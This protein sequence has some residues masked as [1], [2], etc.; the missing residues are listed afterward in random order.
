MSVHVSFQDLTSEILVRFVIYHAFC[1]SFFVV[2]CLCLLL[3]FWQERSQRLSWGSL[4]NISFS[5]ANARAMITCCVLWEEIYLNSLRIWMHFIATSPSPTR[6]L[7]PY[8]SIVFLT[9]FFTEKIVIHCLI[10]A[11][12][13]CAIISGGEEPWWYPAP[14]LLFRP[15]RTL[16]HYSWSLKALP[17]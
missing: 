10:F 13:E 2:F 1:L 11:G 6:C 17:L 4:E 3:F 12:N 8:P 16:S 5:F 9:A 15:Q 7:L 14:P